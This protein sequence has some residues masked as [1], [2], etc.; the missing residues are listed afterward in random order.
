MLAGKLIVISSIFQLEDYIIY[1]S[2]IVSAEENKYVIF[3]P[4]IFSNK[5][6]LIHSQ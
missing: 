1:Q 2:R 5:I 3:I 4:Q 6:D